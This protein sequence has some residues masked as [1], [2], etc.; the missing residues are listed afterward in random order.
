MD[1]FSWGS[2]FTDEEVK[3]KDNLLEI[4]PLKKKGNK[5]RKSD[6]RNHAFNDYAV[7]HMIEERMAKYRELCYFY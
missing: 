4:I 2:N 6:P 7:W 5:S 1:A 3:A